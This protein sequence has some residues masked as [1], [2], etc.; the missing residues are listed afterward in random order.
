MLLSCHSFET[1][2]WI[3]QCHWTPSI[4]TQSET[5]TW[6][7]DVTTAKKSSQ[8][9]SLHA[10]HNYK[11]HQRTHF[12]SIRKH[13]LFIATLGNL[14]LLASPK[15]CPDVLRSSCMTNR[16]LCQR[17][18]LQRK[19]DVVV[20]CTLEDFCMIHSNLSSMFVQHQLAIFY[21]SNTCK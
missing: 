8:S 3:S 1:T 19:W 18:D 5:I 12:N 21:Q 20:I 6:K 4:K 11:G 9:N 16:N 13:M 14:H 7:L 10:T 15:R 17:H 2:R